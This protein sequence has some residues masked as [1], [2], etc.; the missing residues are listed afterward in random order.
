MKLGLSGRRAIVTGA[1]AGIGAAVAEALAAEGAHG[2]GRIVHVGSI[3]A[4]EP[5]RGAAAYGAAKAALVSYSKSLSAE[6]SRYGVLSTVVL[7]GLTETE[8]MVAECRRIME[9]EGLDGDAAS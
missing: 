2:W 4:R 5:G 8:A 6:V 7:P 3:A 9:Q 1:S